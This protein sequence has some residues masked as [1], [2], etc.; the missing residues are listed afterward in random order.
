MIYFDSVGYH[1][2]ANRNRFF[3]DTFVFYPIHLHFKIFAEAVKYRHFSRKL[4]SEI[5]L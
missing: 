4:L 3:Q 2:C 1:R 5:D